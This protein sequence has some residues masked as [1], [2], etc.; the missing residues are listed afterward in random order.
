[1]ETRFV[2]NMVCQR[3]ILAVQQVLTQAQLPWDEVQLGEVRFREALLPAQ[4]G[5]L[6]KVL[7]SLGFELIDDRKTALI[8]KI[9]QLTL[10]YIQT[11]AE[12]GVRQQNL[13]DYITRQLHFDY[14]YL[15]DLFSS[16]EG[17][18]IEN[19]FIAQRIEKAKELL[20]Y[21]QQ[22]ITEIAYELGFSSMHH[23]SAQF[24]KVTGLTPS[25]FRKIG[26]HKRI[27]LDKV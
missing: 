1:M 9:K 7:Q 4:L 3:C 13:S 24:K 20:V 11:I 17:V 2:R 8:E 12:T 5:Q 15:S 27:P 22:T 21:G 26:L 23:L 25:H 19:Y 14:S 18:T 16:V 6:S 10:H